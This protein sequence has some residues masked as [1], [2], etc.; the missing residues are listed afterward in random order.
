MLVISISNDSIYLF[1]IPFLHP[2]AD[3]NSAQN[4]LKG[5]DIKEGQCLWSEDK[6]VW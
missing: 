5:P 6:E 2:G 4:V 3:R 1:S